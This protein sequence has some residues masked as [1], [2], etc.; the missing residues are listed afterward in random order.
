[1]AAGGVARLPRRPPCPGWIWAAPASGWS[2]DLHCPPLPC[3]GC[4]HLTCIPRQTTWSDIRGSAPPDAR[5]TCMSLS[6]QIPDSH[7]RWP[8]LPSPK[9]SRTICCLQAPPWCL[10][11]RVEAL[12]I[13][14]H[15]SATGP[16]SALHGECWS[17]FASGPYSRWGAANSICALWRD[18]RA[19]VAFNVVDPATSKSRPLP[20]VRHCLPNSSLRSLSLNL[21][22][23]ML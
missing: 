11:P 4:R 23:V 21:P 19:A 10:D 2:A 15:G 16:R 22:F 14:H 7:I 8:F 18:M 3:R 13:P 6:P 20:S 9:H 12:K 1:M 17:Q 5:W